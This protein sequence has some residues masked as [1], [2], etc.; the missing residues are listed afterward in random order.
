[1]YIGLYLKKPVIN[2]GH[3]P[4][5]EKKYIKE[6]RI[7]TLDQSIKLGNFFLDNI[8]KACDV[9]VGPYEYDYWNSEKCKIIVSWIEKN[10][11]LIK[12]SKLDDF[13]KVI[14]EYCIKAIE[15]DTGVEIDL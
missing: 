9:L 13:F 8:D 11:N 3:Y 14:N 4:K 6:Y 1:M 15:L 2:Y 7:G 5:I 10:K 12:E